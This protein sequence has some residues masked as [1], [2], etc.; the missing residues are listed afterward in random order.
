MHRIKESQGENARDLRAAMTDAERK[1]WQAIRQSQLG[2]RFRRQHPID[3][4]IADFACLDVKLVVEV[5][6]GQH[7]D[8][9][10]G[11]AERTMVIESY[12]FRVVRFWNNE[13]LQ[14]LDGVLQ[15]IARELAP[16][17][18]PGLPPQK[19]KGKNV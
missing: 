19:G 9:A 3:R 11:D 2:V 16:H 14:N 15:V 5:D 12:G 4:F 10:I 6:G 7:A 13:V 1:L 8:E 17:P 18:H